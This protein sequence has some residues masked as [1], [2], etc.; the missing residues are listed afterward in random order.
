MRND[1]FEWD[2]EKARRNLVKHGVSFD[3]AALVFDDPNAWVEPDESDPD[4]ERWA[5][6]GMATDKVLLVISTDRGT[7]TRIISA[8][9]A[10]QHEEDN[11]YRQALPE[12]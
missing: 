6:T 4:E 8:R 1:R 3:E 5:T 10:S 11:Y 2:D 12:E 7:R 9:R